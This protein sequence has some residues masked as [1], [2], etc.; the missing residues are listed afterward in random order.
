VVGDV[1][2]VCPSDLDGFAFVSHIMSR[3]HVWCSSWALGWKKYIRITTAGWL[4]ARDK[5]M[6]TEGAKLTTLDTFFN[7]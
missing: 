7:L 5:R 2:F 3:K 1:G 6:S 4:S